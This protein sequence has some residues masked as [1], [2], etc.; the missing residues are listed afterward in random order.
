MSM[1]AVTVEPVG[2]REMAVFHRLPLLLQGKDP[3]FVP[4]LLFE[5][6][7]HLDPHANPHFREAEIAF[8]IARRGGRP[9]GRISA[10]IDRVALAH[11]GD[12]TGFF[13]H[14]EV[15][16]DAETANALLAATEAWLRARGMERVRG[17]FEVSVNDR[18]G[19]LVEGRETPPMLM[20]N[21]APPHY[22]RLLEEAGY[23]AV[24]DLLAYHA[25]VDSELPP[26][27]RKLLARLDGRARVR[28]IE[29]RRYRA[30]IDTI[31][32]IFNDA[33]EGNWGFVPLTDERLDHLARSMKPILIEDLVA[34]AEIDGEPAAMMVALPNLNEAIRDLGGRLLPFGWAKL[35]WRLKVGRMRTLRVPLM[36]VRRKY[37]GTLTGAAL[38]MAMFDRIREA[39]HAR[40]FREAELSWVLEDNRPMRH[41]AE[42]M[43]ARIY[44]RYRLYEKPLGRGA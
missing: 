7:R 19:L 31:M 40:G 21:H 10:H 18:C 1:S 11:A 33:W 14:W 9:V 37:H 4:P 8:W 22:G 44:K 23:A 26:Q 16:D 6:R 42:H 43:G 41:M 27:G 36:G 24:R 25:P 2:R 17:P 20:M 28:P 12:A 38:M 32:G 3:A 5:E 39:A 29:W 30:E 13:G 35:L 34:I 15:E